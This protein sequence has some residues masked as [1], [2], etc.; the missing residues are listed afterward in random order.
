MAKKIDKVKKKE[1]ILSKVI[2]I[3][4]E[5]GLRHT[6]MEDIAKAS[7]IGKG[8]LYEYFPSKE[9]LL[10]EVMNFFFRDYF[11]E[12][13]RVLSVEEDPEIWLQKL[14]DINFEILKSPS[15][16]WNIIFDIWA[17]LAR[18]GRGMEWLKNL[19][20]DIRRKIEGIIYKGKE[21][22]KFS[23]LIDA[24][25]LATFLIASLDCLFL[26]KTMGLL[27]GKEDKI[28]RDFRKIFFDNL[29]GAR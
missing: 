26:Q 20:V 27:D 1:F 3:I 25:S 4:G 7:G 8:T 9:N 13:E 28:E 21:M 6:K 14:L 18:K 29:R 23:P 5:K 19:Y 12:M 16:E 22:E 17:E 24:F 2:T 15:T 10:E 11:Q